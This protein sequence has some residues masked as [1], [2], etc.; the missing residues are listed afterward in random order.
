ML[1]TVEAALG[2]GT[3][4]AHDRYAAAFSNIFKTSKTLSPERSLG[5]TSP[6]RLTSTQPDPATPSAPQGTPAARF[7]AAAAE[8]R[9]PIAWVANYAS[10]SV[11]PVNL[12][13]RP[14]GPQIG[15]GPG[16]QA[17]AATPNGKTIY[18]ADS[19][20]GTVT[21]IVTA[22]GRAAHPLNVGADSYPTEITITG[23]TA[24]VVEL[25]GYT[26]ELI[27]LKTRH[28]FPPI[29]VGAFPTAVAITA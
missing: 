6:G 25:Y 1:R 11:S 22:T 23:Q 5:S 27:N 28:V 24:V 21:P 13:T 29:T 14:A 10:N 26:V 4:T 20:S 7:L 12:A 16:P 15:V 9:Q 2:L 17:I 8:A 18:V 19:L 3:L